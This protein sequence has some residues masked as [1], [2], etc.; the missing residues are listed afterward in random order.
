VV[1]EPVLPIG[2]EAVPVPGPVAG[3]RCS[4]THCGLKSSGGT[5]LLLVAMSVPCAVAGVFTR[6]QVAAAPVHLCRERVKGG[7]ARALVVNSGNANACTGEQGMADA[8]RVTKAVADA[9]QIQE[10][11]VFASS[12]GVIGVPLPAE[13]PVAAIPGLVQACRPGDWDGAARAIMTTDTVPKFRE[14]TCTIDGVPVRIVGIAKGSGMIHPNMATMLC[15]LF[16]D[17]AVAAPALQTLLRMAVDRSFNN[18]SVDGDTSTNDSVLV[19]ASGLARHRPVQWPEDPRLR[20]FQ[21]ALTGVCTDLAQAI[22]R[23]GEG[24][25]KFLT[26]TVTGAASTAAARA[27]AHTVAGSSLVK[28]ALFGQDPNW[29]R[30]IA[31]VGRAG[32][33]L[34]VH[35]LTIDL[36]E[37]RIVEQGAR[38]ATYR[39]EL[40]AAVMQQKEI[41]VRID[42]H[43]GHAEQTVWSCD[44]SYDYVRINAD[45]TT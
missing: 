35:R 22:V 21:T 15:Y 8:R 1:A 4:S 39:E 32:V 45:Y 11:T 42:L 33:P 19:F 10:E 9:L 14:R 13:R 7:V 17:A 18:I 31:A 40:G 36:G 12:T 16:T 3:F 37:V 6:N 28:T 38:A 5:D 2:P 20:E 41:V 25:T 23:D 27:V 24:A 43:Q 34:E 26:V 44:L 29:G 30:I